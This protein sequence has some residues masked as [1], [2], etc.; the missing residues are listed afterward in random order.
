MNSMLLRHE[1]IIKNMNDYMTLLHSQGVG[2]GYTPPGASPDPQGTSPTTP[3]VDPN[4]TNRHNGVQETRQNLEKVDLS[5]KGFERT[6]QFMGLRDEYIHWKERV[7]EH[8]TKGTPELGALLIWAQE[9]KTRITEQLEQ[10]SEYMLHNI[11][12]NAVLAISEVYSYLGCYIGDNV[13]AKKLNA[14]AMRGLELRRTLYQEYEGSSGSIMAAK[15]SSFLAPHRASSMAE[16]SASLDNWEVL[17]HQCGQ[18]LTD[19]VRG[20]IL[21][22]LVPEGLRDKRLEKHDLTTLQQK[23]SYVRAHMVDSRNSEIAK[24]IGMPLS[25][26]KKST[27]VN[28]YDVDVGAV[29]EQPDEWDEDPY[30]KLAEALIAYAGQGG[31]GK[32]W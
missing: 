14:G 18:H 3:N 28:K 7:F 24:G 32:G 30:A 29:G 1:V 17:G 20:S 31:K 22:N 6:K 21:A 26:V 23:L 13:R 2:S 10:E 4:T 19:E 8:I 25:K 15:L 27:P 5:H 11:S 16:L 12:V 9:Q